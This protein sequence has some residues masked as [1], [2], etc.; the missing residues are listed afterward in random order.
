MWWKCDETTPRLEFYQ[1]R[2]HGSRWA[3]LWPSND[4]IDWSTHLPTSG[5]L[6]WWLSGQATRLPTVWPIN[7]LTIALTLRM[8][9]SSTYDDDY[10]LLRS[11]VDS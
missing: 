2:W 10:L 3:S 7:N 6:V 5:S 1:D 11:T 9:L 8:M 4:L